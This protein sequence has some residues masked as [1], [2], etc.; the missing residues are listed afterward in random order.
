[1]ARGVPTGDG[2]EAPNNQE[3]TDLISQL[4]QVASPTRPQNP[5]QATPPA[6]SQNHNL[7]G[8]PAAIQN[9]DEG[10]PKPSQ[11]D[12]SHMSPAEAAVAKKA[13][14]KARKSWTDKLNHIRRQ[15]GLPSPRPRRRATSGLPAG[16]TETP[17]KVTEKAD[18]LES[19]EGD[20]SKRIKN[21]SLLGESTE[22]DQGQ[23]QGQ[24]PNDEVFPATP[25]NAFPVDAGET[26]LQ[27]IHDE[28]SPAISNDVVPAFSGE[29]VPTSH[30]EDRAL[31]P[32]DVLEE[33]G[34]LPFIGV[35]Y[36][37]AD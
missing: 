20:K 18:D 25:D 33:D 34:W 3:R 29:F 16:N 26:P 15:A 17:S 13:A 30:D 4:F 35:S 8:S 7:T 12:T 10:P 11:I 22:E 37:S 28:L 2:C 36:Y 9:Q 19:A 1:M 31:I 5:I 27:A 23:N 21:L 32:T 6:E 24:A 14:Q